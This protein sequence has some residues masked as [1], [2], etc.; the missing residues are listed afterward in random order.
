M[1]VGSWESRKQPH[2]LQEVQLKTH[3]LLAGG[4]Q[5]LSSNTGSNTGPMAAAAAAA[6]TSTGRCGG[7]GSNHN[8]SRNMAGSSWVPGCSETNVGGWGTC[9]G[10]GALRNKGKGG[11]ED[12][13][14]RASGL[15]VGCLHQAQL[16]FCDTAA[17][18]VCEVPAPRQATKCEEAQLHKLKLC[19]SG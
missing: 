14:T 16:L 4:W 9:L 15:V 10:Y 11:R 12:K 17:V 8:N 5:Q 2:G 18:D 7:G 6:T 1:L 3:Q 13:L 19:V